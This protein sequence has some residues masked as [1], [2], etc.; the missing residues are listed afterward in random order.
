MK[1]KGE[2]EEDRGLVYMTW[3]NRGCWLLWGMI[4]GSSISQFVNAETVR[5]PAQVRAFR[6]IHPCPATGKARGACPDHV[7]D[8]IV[9]LCAGGADSPANMQW[10]TVVAGKQKDRLERWICAF[11]RKGKGWACP[12]PDIGKIK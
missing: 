6:S 5:D 7:V 2:S 4:I 10:Q 9:P 12:A 3:V 1:Y 11:K 8:H